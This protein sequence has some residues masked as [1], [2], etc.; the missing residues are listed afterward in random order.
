MFAENHENNFCL[1]IFMRFV[2][3]LLFLVGASHEKR[4]KRENK[5]IPKK[6]KQRK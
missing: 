1:G 4:E 6:I 2:L 5:N 3:R